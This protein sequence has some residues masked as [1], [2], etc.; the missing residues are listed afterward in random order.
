MHLWY[1]NKRVFTRANIEG[2]RKFLVVAHC[3]LD[4]YRKRKCVRNVFSLKNSDCKMENEQ[5]TTKT[6]IELCA[7][8]VFPQCVDKQIE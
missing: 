7:S 2:N 1:K 8:E 4:N 3:I 6:E 5:I